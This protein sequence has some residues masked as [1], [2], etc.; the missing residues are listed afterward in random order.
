M[1]HTLSTR[2]EIPL[3]VDK[4]FEF[5]ATAE[6]LQRL[7]PPELQFRILTPKP[8]E[9]RQGALIDYQLGLFGL[10][11]RW[12]TEITNWDPPHQ[13]IDVQLRGPYREWIHTH[14]FIPTSKGTAILD[15]VQYQL[16]FSPLGDLAY[17]VVRLQ[18]AR[19]F[20]YR[21]TAVRRLLLSE[22]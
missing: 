18:L 14:R 12:K 6:N 19:I 16:P 2:L 11:F 1:K 10:K 4:V 8:I 9:L 5:F 3:P 20:G 21:Q 22:T 13:F 7:T 15:D 17:P